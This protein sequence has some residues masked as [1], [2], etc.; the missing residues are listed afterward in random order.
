MRKAGQPAR[1][2]R[3]DVTDSVRVGPPARRCYAP[4]PQD[5]ADIRREALIKAGLRAPNLREFGLDDDY[6]KTLCHPPSALPKLPRCA[7]E[8]ST[9]TGASPFPIRTG[10]KLPGK[11]RKPKGF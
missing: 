7:P 6:A 4:P 5:P 3:T 10:M 9:W 2:D 11:G 1:S 8:P